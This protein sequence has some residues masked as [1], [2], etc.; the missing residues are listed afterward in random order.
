MRPIVTDRVAWTVGLSVCR[1]VTLVSH[2]KPLFGLKTLLGPGNHV[3]DRGLDPNM[4]RGNFLRKGIPLWSI[5]TLYGH[6]CRNGWTNRDAVWVVGS[7]GSKKS[8]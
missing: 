5:G 8:C 1:S 6:M 2:T 4:G 7:D 3:L